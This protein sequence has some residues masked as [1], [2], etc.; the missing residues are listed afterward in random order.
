MPMPVLAEV[1]TA[2]VA[3]MPM[4]CS[5][6]SCAI[7]G[8]AEGRSILL[9]HRDD[10]EVVVD[11]EVG[12]GERLR[13]DALRRVDDQQRALAGG[14]RARDLVGEVD[15]PG[16]VDQVEDV[17]LAVLGLVVELTDARLD[18]DAALAL[19]VHVVEHLLAS[20]RVPS[21]RPCAR[22]S[23]RRASTC[24]GRCGRR[25][26]SCG[27]ARGR[28]W[29]G[30]AR[31]A[32]RSADSSGPGLAGLTFQFLRT[33][34]TTSTGI[35]KPSPCASPS[36]FQVLTPTSRPAESTS[37]P[38]LLPGLIAASCWRKER[39]C[40]ES[41]TGCVT[42]PRVTE[43]PSSGESGEPIAQTWSP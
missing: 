43:K 12:V 15:V 18:R 23:G 3:S 9:M 25:S 34:S 21:A 19:E 7:S 27:C 32:R 8:S 2:C 4:T 17:V 22:G 10:L 30:A 28:S 29:G 6:C 1:S 14:E 20:S 16:G 35:A 40:K 24:R 37:G 42:M 39:P 33:S 13:L 31:K 36:T 26:R 41:A 5:I 11:R 38:P